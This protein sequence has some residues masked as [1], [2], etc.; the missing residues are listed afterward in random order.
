LTP[1]EPTGCTGPVELFRLVEPRGSG[2][3]AT[4]FEPV[5]TALVG[6]T[7][8][9][10]LL[11]ALAERA[12]AGTR[13]A[14][15][16]R[17]EAG[18]GKTRLIQ[19]LRATAEGELGMRRLHCESSPCHRG[20]ALHPIVEGLRRL[21]TLDGPDA[22]A[23]LAGPVADRAGFAG[24][25]R[26]ATLLAG[27]LGLASPTRELEPISPQRRRRETLTAV[28]NALGSEAREQPLL[29]VV[30]DLHWADATT[31]ELLGG[32]V[33]G[34]HDLPLLLAMSARPEFRP[35]WTGTLQ[36]LDL[37]RMERAETLRL[38]GLVAGETELA[39]ADV[40]EIAS[41]AEGVPLLAEELT[42]A[43]L[44]RQ[45]EGRPIPMT[46]FGCL[47]ARLDRDGTERS[48]AQLA[49]TIGREF[50]AGLLAA[51][52]GADASALQ[53]GLERLVADEVVVPTGAGTYAFQ[54]AL[55][56]DAA[57]SSLRKHERRNH[58]RRIARAL[59][60]QF[61]DLAAAQPERVARH[62]EYGGEMIEAVSH[63]QRA[64]LHALRQAAYREATLHFERA[65]TLVSRLPDG[66][67]RGSIELTL[68]ML[69]CLPITATYG[70]D[71]AAFVTHYERAEELSRR[72]D[73]TPKLFG[74][75]LGLVANRMVC[76]HIEEAVALGRKQIAVAE[77]V[78]D[79]DL[80]LEAECEV[81]RSRA[82]APCCAPVRTPSATRGCAVRPRRWRSCTTSAAPSC[83]RP[84]P[85]S[86][87]RRVRASTTGW[88]WRRCCA[89]GRACA[90]AIPRRWKRC[91][92][93][94][95]DGRAAAS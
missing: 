23:R 37:R 27:L 88:R 46:L 13:S 47:M 85:P 9:R 2:R 70:W 86:R 8:E 89:A 33:N 72:I 60:A 30:E 4:G 65:Q 79:P 54:H 78:G 43:V 77:A 5:P 71:S 26:A 53:W 21:W 76:G 84:T 38:I 45:G 74:A 39:A 48:V 31:L 15:L 91:S 66:T 63:W 20:S 52:E 95:P 34:A 32:L 1:R 69:A 81:R 35:G 59:L 90:V 41:R 67:A 83:A 80:V 3:S 44:A 7:G 36:R 6:R 93:A 17:G 12:A 75:M 56:Q 50:D 25:E 64:G 14:V 19:A 18:I 62:F 16:L 10:A 51:G 24:D 61:P 29:V 55:V 92:A 57:R 58:D 73:G 68:H 40:E 28:L 87:S 22:A 94:W 49:A 42:R 11:R 82:R